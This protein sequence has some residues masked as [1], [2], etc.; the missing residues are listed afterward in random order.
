MV[1]NLAVRVV[2]VASVMGVG[3]SDMPQSSRV[4]LG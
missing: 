3:P 4:L 1:S 2:V